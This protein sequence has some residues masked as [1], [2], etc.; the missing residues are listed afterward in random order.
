MTNDA[1]GG[2]PPDGPPKGLLA[3]VVSATLHE[4]GEEATAAL[5]DANAS[6]A[7]PDTTIKQHHSSLDPAYAE[8]PTLDDFK[9]MV[10]EMFPQDAPDAPN[11]CGVPMD[12]LKIQATF[13][14]LLKR[15][16]AVLEAVKP[17]ATKAMLMA[18]AKLNLCADRRA[19]EPAGGTWI[20]GL[21]QIHMSADEKLFFALCDAYG[22]KAAERVMMDA[23]ERI[24]KAQTLL[25]EKAQHIE[26]GKAIH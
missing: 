8:P 4:K 3:A 16:E 10:A 13:H 5:A 17:L 2:S 26:N 12:S 7:K 14:L 25:A 22:R 18:N 23:F 1:G 9:K 6:A 21:D 11:D 24:Q 19:G 15:L 20:S